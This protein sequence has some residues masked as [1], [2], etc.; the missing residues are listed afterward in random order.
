MTQRALTDKTVSHNTTHCSF[1]WNNYFRSFLEICQ[2]ISVFFF[3]TEARLSW[4]PTFPGSDKWDILFHTSF[5]S[6]SKRIIYLY[7]F[8]FWRM[9]EIRNDKNKQPSTLLHCIFPPYITLYIANK[10]RQFFTKVCSIIISYAVLWRKRKCGAGV[11]NWISAMSI[12]WSLV[13]ASWEKHQHC[14]LHLSW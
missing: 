2:T 9:S 14:P 11:S 1:G 4:P 12:W 6:S 5:Q 7:L 3:C 13:P 10:A 8:H